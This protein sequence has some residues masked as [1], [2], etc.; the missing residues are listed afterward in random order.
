ME[1][2]YHLAE[3]CQGQGYMR[4]AKAAAM[5]VLWRLIPAEVMEAGAQLENQASFSVMAALGM[6]PADERLVYSSV[7]DRH[8]P[9]RF[10]ELRRPR[11]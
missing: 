8:E 5:P 6:T 7:R 10:F 4:E 3:D 1:I 9:T 2:S 11:S